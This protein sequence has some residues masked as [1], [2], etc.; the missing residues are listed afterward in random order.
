MIDLTEDLKKMAFEAGFISLG[1]TSPENLRELPYGWATD[2]MYLIPP[3]KVLA[4]T[5]S[6]IILVFYRWDKAFSL[7][8]D[9]PKWKN[10]RAH[11]DEEKIEGYFMATQVIMNKAWPIVYTLRERGHKAII[12]TSIPLKTTA[13]KC[14]LG[15]QGKSTLLVH[16]MFGPN[17]ALI[18]ILTT[19]QLSINEP[20]K[21]DLCGNCTRCVEACP[22]GAL[23]PYRLNYIRCL[24][25]AAENP[26]KNEVPMDVRELEKKYI[27]R[28]SENS[29]IEC[30]TCI[31]VCPIS[32]GRGG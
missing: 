29:Y 28:P 6:V 31:D 26:R 2:E 3:E 7:Q 8:I 16:P 4:G 24:T 19:A 14:G 11:S 1:I 13:I 9:S 20:F 18:S 30:T 32:T 15:Y 17:L 25:Y 22:S 10:H 21:E 23:E 27:V 5:K 12:S